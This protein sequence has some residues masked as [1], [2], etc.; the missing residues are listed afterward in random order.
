[1]LQSVLVARL[2][3]GIMDFLHELHVA[4]TRFR[5]L[6]VAFFGLLFVVK[7]RRPSHLNDLWTEKRRN[8][9]KNEEH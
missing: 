8:M 6:S 4:E 1:M 5:R 3:P 7:A 2:T 9:S